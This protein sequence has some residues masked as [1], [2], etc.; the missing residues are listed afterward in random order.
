MTPFK[1]KKPCSKPGCPRLTDGGRCE[2]HKKQAEKEYEQSRGTAAERGYDATWARVR[3]MKM[4]ADPLCERCLL[5]GRD[6]AAIL[7]HH[8]DRNSMNNREDNLESLCRDCHD[9]EHK[10]ERWQGR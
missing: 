4:N 7:V 5:N 1:P 9:E 6:V 3:L 8:K 10:Q 2:Q